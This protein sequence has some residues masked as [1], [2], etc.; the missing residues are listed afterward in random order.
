MNLHIQKK[1]E[2]SLIDQFFKKKTL[3]RADVS[4]GIGDDAALLT[5]PAD[6]ELVMAVDTLVEGVHFPPHTTPQEIGYKALAVN[7]S[8][9][10]AMGA[11]PAWMLL[12]ATLPSADKEWIEQFSA[13]LF[14][15]AQSF[16]V[17]LVGGDSTRGPLTVTVQITGFVPTHKALCRHGA[18][19]GDKI[20]V[21]G[22]LGDAGLGLQ[23]ATGKWQLSGVDKAQALQRLNRPFPRVHLGILLREYASSA[24]DISDGLLADLGHL[25]TASRVGAYVDAEQLPLSN[26]L[27]RTLALNEARKLALTAGDD[28]ELCF[29]VAPAKE[30][31]LLEQL[32]R[33]NITCYCIGE[34]TDH[35]E[36]INLHGVTGS[37]D[38]LGFTHWG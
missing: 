19:V 33:E 13:G 38:Q 8:D 9:L 37:L 36:T 27:C 5:V 16:N 1:A 34:I 18:K 6:H 3:M 20:Y 26:L 15:L 32:A 22:P 7:L 12:A 28:Y 17:Q 10:A 11:T 35:L 2:F 31:A 4:L 29:T 14:E 21:S 30:S 24:I 25:L 23:V